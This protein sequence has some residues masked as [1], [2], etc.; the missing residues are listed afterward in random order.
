VKVSQVPWTKSQ[1]KVRK[2][3]PSDERSQLKLPQISE[4]H[5]KQKIHREKKLWGNFFAFSF[6]LWKY[7]I[8]ILSPSLKFER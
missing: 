7:S 6:V 5:K 4:T 8:L 1:I 3:F 2:Q